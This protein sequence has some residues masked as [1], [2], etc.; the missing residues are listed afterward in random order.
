MERS[1]LEAMRRSL[2]A[3]AGASLEA[4]QQRR[5]I[6]QVLL[7]EGYKLLASSKPA[8]A[9]EVCA[10]LAD[11]AALADEDRARIAGHRA[12]ALAALDRVGEAIDALRDQPARAQAIGAAAL[13]R[14]LCRAG[15]P[16]EA[17]AWLDR[18]GNDDAARVG[19]LLAV[20]GG[21]LARGDLRRAGLTLAEAEKRA[22]SPVLLGRTQLLRGRLG[23][24][25]GE[26]EAAR[27]AYLGARETLRPKQKSV[28]VGSVSVRMAGEGG[29]GPGRRPE[30][31]WL[32]EA[33]LA[34]G[35]LALK[36]ADWREASSF[37]R[38]AHEKSSRWRLW[39]TAGEAAAALARGCL[40]HGDP[41][42]GL[43]YV[44]R[45]LAHHEIRGMRP[46]TALYAL[47]AELATAAGDTARA[48]DFRRRG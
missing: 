36:R 7:A 4:R 26:V 30:D 41:H 43:T 47:G 28:V 15:R 32:A 2:D 34:L 45:A 46:D 18:V 23:E 39:Q 9:L 17:V 42:E 13:V 3:A 38:E 10:L 5:Q 1:E 16:E 21:W 24:A 6:R 37:L 19:A 33:L 27:A 12:A 48:A 14:A 22:L 8:A 35:R 25:R 11:V 44:E 40:E 20:A 29:E 31:R